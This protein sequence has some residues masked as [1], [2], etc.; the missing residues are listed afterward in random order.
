MQSVFLFFHCNA[1]FFSYQIDPLHNLNYYNY[2]SFI[3]SHP[4]HLILPSIPSHGTLY[5]FHFLISYLIHLNLSY[6][7][8]IYNI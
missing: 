6:G 4:H 2:S 8:L 1:F 5:L 7:S 3:S